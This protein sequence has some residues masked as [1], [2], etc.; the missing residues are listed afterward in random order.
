MPKVVD[1]K[2]RRQEIVATAFGLIARGGMEA[3]T[4]REIAR[5]S[6]YSKGVVEHYFDNKEELVSA[7]LDKANERFAERVATAANGQMGLAGLEASLLATLPVTPE[8]REEW[9]VR[10]SFWAMAAIN[11]ALQK[12]QQ[13][14]FTIA[15]SYFA[16]HLSMAIQQQEIDSLSSISETARHLLNFTGGIAAAAVHNPDFYT[17]SVL[18]KEAAYLIRQVKNGF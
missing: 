1:H 5:Q 12:D 3:A 7:A 16:E 4:I 11:D 17:A 15:A 10:L 2:A 13:K 14:R 18:E 8:I 6:G 9:K